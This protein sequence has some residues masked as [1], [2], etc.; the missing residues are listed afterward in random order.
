VTQ[1]EAKDPPAPPRAAAAAH[2]HHHHPQHY[3]HSAKSLLGASVLTRLAIVVAV[4][5]V[6]WV[7]IAWALA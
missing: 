5:A 2:H 7:A 4:S 3:R 6:L 1:A